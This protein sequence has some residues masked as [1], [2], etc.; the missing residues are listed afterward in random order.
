P[1]PSPSPSPTA[2]CTDG[3]LH[4][5]FGQLYRDNVGV[6]SRLGCPKDIERTGASSEQFFKGGTMFYWGL[7]PTGLRDSI[8]IFYGLNSGTYGIVSADESAA[9]PEPPPNSDPDAPA[10]GFGRVYYG[11]A[12]VAEALGAWTSPEIEL[13]GSSL[14]VIQFFDGGTMIYTP[15]YQQ[16]GASEQTIFVLYADGAFERYNDQPAG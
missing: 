12:G 16:P 3:R 4:G 9:F 1:S 6:R 14:G 7:N 5:G 10:H 15:T 8:V 11:K 2:D 13:K